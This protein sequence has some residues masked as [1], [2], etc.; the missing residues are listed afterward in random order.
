MLSVKHLARMC[1]KM[2]GDRREG[3]GRITFQ[4]VFMVG[5]TSLS[6]GIKDSSKVMHFEM[7]NESDESGEIKN[8]AP[9]YN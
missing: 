9:K 3:V 4:E 2:T 6:P 5:L 7:Q 1:Y 8:R